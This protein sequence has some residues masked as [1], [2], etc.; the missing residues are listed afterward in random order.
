MPRI[1][2]QWLPEK[3]TVFIIRDVEERYIKGVYRHHQDALDLVESYVDDMV[4]DGDGEEERE[5][6]R[7]LYEIL[8]MPVE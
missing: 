5:L 3:E 8:E 7:G 4:Y 2:Q 6:A 1:P